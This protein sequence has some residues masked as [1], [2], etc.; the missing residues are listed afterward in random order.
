MD[1]VLLFSVLLTA[2]R[3]MEFKTYPGFA[4]QGIGNGGSSF[5]LL[6]EARNQSRY[7]PGGQVTALCSITAMGFILFLGRER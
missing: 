5:V 4:A 2:R 7:L 6:F 3:G 1:M